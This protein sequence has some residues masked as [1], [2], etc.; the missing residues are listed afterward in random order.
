MVPG[1]SLQPR[2]GALLVG[3]RCQG[4][5]GSN[6]QHCATGLAHPGADGVAHPG[7]D[8]HHCSTGL[9]RRPD[10]HCST[11]LARP[12]ADDHRSSSD[13]H[14]RPGHCG[15]HAAGACCAHHVCHSGRACRGPD[16][17]NAT[18]HAWRKK[19]CGGGEPWVGLGA[20][21]DAATNQEC[22]RLVN[23]CLMFAPRTLK[24]SRLP[25]VGTTPCTGNGF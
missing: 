14:R 5:T 17:G 16:A 10:R 7:A 23:G 13:L 11:G 24:N 25:T 22:A 12:P 21:S 15:A 6:D 20:R 8:D 2:P 3:S 19:R 9:E 1:S 18:Y 4:S